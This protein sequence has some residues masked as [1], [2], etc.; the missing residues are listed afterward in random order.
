VRD[1]FVRVAE[2]VFFTVEFLPTRTTLLLRAE[3]DNAVSV[4]DYRHLSIS[5]QIV[6]ST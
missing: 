6:S 2:I 4:R 5:L 1:R 3:R